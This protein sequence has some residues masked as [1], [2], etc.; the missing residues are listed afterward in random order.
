VAQLQRSLNLEQGPTF[1]AA[2]MMLDSGR[3]RVAMVIHHLVVDALSWQ[4]LM[5]ELAVLYAAFRSGSQP[6]LPPLGS[7]YGEWAERLGAYGASLPPAEASSPDAADETE[8]LRAWMRSGSDVKSRPETRSLVIFKLDREVTRALMGWLSGTRRGGAAALLLTLLAKVL[9]SCTGVRRIPIAVETHG[10]AELFP[11]LDISSTVGWFT[12]TAPIA[13]SVEASASLLE[14]TARVQAQLDEQVERAAIAGIREQLASASRTGARA[15]ANGF[16]IVFNYLGGLVGEEAHGPFSSGRIVREDLVAAGLEWP[17]TL[18]IDAFVEA[19]ALNIEWRFAPGS[20]SSA[21]VHEL[22]EALGRELRQAIPQEVAGAG[23]EVEEGYPLTHVQAGMLFQT[24][25]DEQARLYHQQLAMRVGIPWDAVALRNAWQHVVGMHAVLRSRVSWER[26]EPVQL[27]QRT[28]A[29][30]FQHVALPAGADADTGLQDFLDADLRRGFDLRVGPL[31]RLSLLELGPS[32]SFVVLSYHHVLLD[33]GSIPLLLRDLEDAY[34]ALAQG[35]PAPTSSRA[36]FRHFVDWVLARDTRLAEAAWTRY[37]AGL[38]ARPK[39]LTGRR[40]PQ[41]RPVTASLELS[42][43]QTRS[44]LEATRR[45]RT[46]LS[47]VLRSAWGVVLGCATASPDVLFGTV[48][49]GRPAELPGAARMIGVLINTVPFRVRW[50]PSESFVGLTS[51]TQ[52]EWLEV[53]EFEHTPLQKLKRLAGF[54]HDGDPF[55]CL[56]TFVGEDLVPGEDSIF[57]G[58][59]T[60]VYSTRELT[61]YGLSLDANVSGEQLRLKLTCPADPTAEANAQALL[62]SYADAL[63]KLPDRAAEPMGTWWRAAAVSATYL[64]ETRALAATESEASFD[65]IHHVEQAVLQVWQEVLGMSALKREDNLFELGGDSISSL[66]IVSRLAQK[67]FS[68]SVRQV[69]EC[70]TAGALAR[71]L[72]QPA[73]PAESKGSSTRL[74]APVVADVKQRY[75]ASVERVLGLTPVQRMILKRH[76]DGLAGTLFH[77]QSMFEYQGEIDIENLRRAWR[78]VLESNPSLRSVFVWDDEAPVQVVLAQ[79]TPRLDVHD[80]SRLTS[81]ERMAFIER[82]RADDLR[83]TFE[84]SRA[85]LIRLAL[86]KHGPDRHSMML[87]FHVMLM[88]GWCFAFVLSELHQSYAALVEGQPLPR[89]GRADFG[90]YVE[91]L[92]AQDREEGLRYW[93]AELSEMAGSLGIPDFRRDHLKVPHAEHP[94]RAERAVLS[95]ELTAKLKAWAARERVTVNT[96]VQ[97]AWAELLQRQTGRSTVVFGSTVS[98]R[99]PE[100]KGADLMVGMFFNDVPVRVNFQPDEERGAVARRVQQ[101]FSSMRR[102]EYFSADDLRGAAGVPPG[103]ELFQSLLVFENYPKE[104]EA[105]LRDTRKQYMVDVGSWRREVSDLDMTVYVEVEDSTSV[106]IRYLADVFEPVTIREC[107]QGYLSILQEF[108]D[109]DGTPLRSAGPGSRRFLQTG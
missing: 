68:T 50:S 96:L 106:E 27:V 55:E 69:F 51:R 2:L 79:A 31:V 7:S 13:V 59:A 70:Q 49:A 12:A 103:T 89:S 66:R 105:Q 32:D 9:S 107:L 34:T 44:L 64:P 101:R 10:R 17:E 19:G 16:Q 41:A 90:D 104:L 23:E 42:A 95:A 43:Q 72:T 98:G 3:S 48:V 1:R 46:T 20:I 84:P 54:P 109:S 37:L 52:G 38:P 4:A 92:S 6:E 76:A 40:Q 83:D 45:W 30:S 25:M 56:F 74:P 21:R 99:P 14:Q 24:L 62:E 100:L 77:D 22:S 35:K 57:G 60:T 97:T 5:K 75:G 11:E 78:H 29:P 82:F 81:E 71:A 63:A 80:L 8:T 26:E 87:G 15:V 65:S 53:Q 102:Y 108:A 88:D 93:R 94:I 61:H 73:A 67:G 39:C 36:P 47:H 85:P 86:L 58:R 91:W 33:G 18:D 28:P